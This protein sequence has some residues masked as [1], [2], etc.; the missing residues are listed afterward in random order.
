[1]ASRRLALSVVAVLLVGI[2]CSYKD[3]GPRMVLRSFKV[4]SV[5]PN[6][7]HLVLQPDDCPT[8][9]FVV[10]ASFT[11]AR[12][13]RHKS[14]LSCLGALQVGATVRHERQREA[15]G[16]TRGDVAYQLLGNCALGPLLL[17][18]TGTRC[19]AK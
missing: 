11:T 7:L 15:Q 1:M 12:A 6:P 19:H 8:E 3:R 4:V 17:K 14:N 13:M 5:T 9:Q 10:D 2:A 16:C 18:P